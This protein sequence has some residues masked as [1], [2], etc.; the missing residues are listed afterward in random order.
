M[1][2]KKASAIVLCLVVMLIWMYIPED[3]YEDFDE[4]VLPNF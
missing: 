2:W 1:N 3:E 4:L